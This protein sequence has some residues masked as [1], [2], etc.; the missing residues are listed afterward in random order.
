MRG[1]GD[2]GA[3]CARGHGPPVERALRLGAGA[4]IADTLGAKGRNRFDDA[5][6]IRR[7]VHDTPPFDYEADTALLVQRVFTVLTFDHFE[8]YF[9][10]PTFS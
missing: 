5:Q 3:P 4:V 9:A 6:A 2:A 10:P 7:A 8:K 1:A